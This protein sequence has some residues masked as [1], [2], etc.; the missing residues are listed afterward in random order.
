M[1]ISKDFRHE[2]QEYSSLLRAL[3]S[4]ATGNLSQH[5]L[6]EDVRTPTSVNDAPEP[7]ALKPQ[8]HQ[9]PLAR[10]D[11]TSWSR[12]PLM[13]DE[14]YPPNFSFEEEVASIAERALVTAADNDET[15]DTNGPLEL[16]SQQDASA[17]A[18]TTAQAVTRTF[19]QAACNF[20]LVDKHSQ[21]RVKP[22]SWK[23]LLEIAESQCTF[24]PE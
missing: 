15:V 7:F 6:Y 22:C 5:I 9:H 16:L 8:E 4:S 12:W 21:S 23:E 20:P 13:P 14:V 24:P 2:L 10:P 19:A 1:P 11:K 18:S 3:K 17:L